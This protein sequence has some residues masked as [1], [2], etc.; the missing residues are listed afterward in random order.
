MAAAQLLLG[1]QASVQV[2]HMVILSASV[3]HCCQCLSDHL[4][5]CV[6]GEFYEVKCHEGPIARL[7]VSY[8]DSLLVSSGE[9]GSVVLMDIRDKELAKAS[10]RQQQVREE[11]GVLQSIQNLMA[12]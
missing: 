8:D 3:S 1:L 7:R 5:S 2:T 6:L 9:D 12:D 10:S 11:E 4:C